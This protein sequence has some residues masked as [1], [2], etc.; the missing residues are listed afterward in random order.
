MK[1]R[2]PTESFMNNIPMAE[3]AD[4][5]DSTVKAE[6]AG[7]TTVNP[8][9]SFVM[10]TFNRKEVLKQALWLVLQQDYEPKE[11]IVI[12]N[13]SEDGT[14][15][16]MQLEFSG[17]NIQYIRLSENKGAAGGKN[18]GISRANG[19]FIIVTDDDALFESNDATARIVKRFDDE[20]DVGLLSLK[21]IDF[22]TREVQGK[23]FPHVDKS[24][25]P[26]QEFETSYF[27]GTGHAVRRDVVD[28]VGLYC[29]DFFPYAFEELDWSFRIINAGFKIVYF[30]DAVVLHKKAP[31]GRISEKSMWTRMLEN[32]IRTSIRNLPWRYV[33]S[34]SFIWACYVTL[35]T[36]G[37]VRVVAQALWRI[38][39]H[40]KILNQQR[41]PISTNALR[42]I[43][44]LRGRLV[45]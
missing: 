43:K 17:Q 9:V 42:R 6:V 33:I 4:Q 41:R 7:K 11:I 2:N 1:S 5:K 18:E 24:L 44:R 45:Y 12:D 32:R 31:Q 38:L 8:L 40:T 22:Q 25:D 35:K 26:D 10:A 3:N 15:E 20:P 19:K 36:K 13:N 23:E 27:V 28:K 39:T 34:S 16:M 37:D 14:A 29:D 30:P 21:S